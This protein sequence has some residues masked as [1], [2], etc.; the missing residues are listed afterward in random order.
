MNLFVVD[1]TLGE[2]TINYKVNQKNP[3]IIMPKDFLLKTNVE[4]HLLVEHKNN[5]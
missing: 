5:Q 2:H 1:L 3:E 4:Y